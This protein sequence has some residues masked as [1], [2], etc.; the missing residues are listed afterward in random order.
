MGAGQQ[1]PAAGFRATRCLA[2]EHGKG[3]V[4]Q[5]KGVGFGARQTSLWAVGESLAVLPASRA[6]TTQLWEAL[7][8][9]NE[10]SCIMP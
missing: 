6:N 4:V 1:P 5:W 8:E 2:R 7:G 3:Q 10:V 9:I